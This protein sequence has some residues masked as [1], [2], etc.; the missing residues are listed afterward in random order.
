MEKANALDT[1]FLRQPIS[2]LVR[3]CWLTQEDEVAQKDE[4][5]KTVMTNVGDFSSDGGVVRVVVQDGGEEVQHQ[6]VAITSVVMPLAA[7][8]LFPARRSSRPVSGFT[9]THHALHG[10][11]SMNAIWACYLVRCNMCSTAL[12]A[13]HSMQG[14]TLT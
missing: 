1:L 2:G 9:C 3:L 4:D 13:L 8:E 14:N 5:L 10:I 6:Q 7:E 11:F 12:G